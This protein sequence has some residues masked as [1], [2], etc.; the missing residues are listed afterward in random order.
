MKFTKIIKNLK[1]DHDHTVYHR[2]SPCITV[3][4]LFTTVL[5]LF[6]TVFGL[7]TTVLASLPLYWPQYPYPVPGTA[8]QYPLPVPHTHYPGTHHPHPVPHHPTG[9]T[10]AP[11]S[12]G[13]DVF[14]RLLLD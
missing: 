8:P 9:Y 5:G 10:A 4:G 3:L 12:D 1:I 13:H 14:T 2:V 7:F 6:T 11:L